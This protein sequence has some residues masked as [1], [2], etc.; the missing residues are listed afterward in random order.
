MI[1]LILASTFVV[2]LRLFMDAETFHAWGWRLPFIFSILLLSVAL[3]IWLQLEESSVFQRMK[4]VGATS[5][6]PL[7]EAFG[8]LRILK[9]FLISL[10]GAVEGQAGIGSAGRMSAVLG[11]SWDI[12]VKPV[13]RRTIKQKLK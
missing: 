11:T 6:A 10:F 12:S 1:G 5:K 3:W 8:E 7:K 2:S 9:I 4:Q 13:G